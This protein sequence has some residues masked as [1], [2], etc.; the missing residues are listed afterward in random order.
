M[1]TAKHMPGA[2][3]TVLLTA[4]MLALFVS[5]SALAASLDSAKADGWI[6]E[7]PDGYLGLV[8][9]DAPADVKALVQDVNGK[10]KAR[11][12][13]I[14]NQQGAPLAEVEKV[15]GQTAIDKTRPGN[16]VM[17]ASGRWRK[18]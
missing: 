12:Q 16:Y 17:D 1:N 2:R 8:R 15:G 11:Y 18:K 4:L 14:A 3:W 9:D 6:G 5:G 13:Q 7:K 10:R